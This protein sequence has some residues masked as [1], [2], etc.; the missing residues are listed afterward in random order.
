MLGTKSSTE[1]CPK[2]LGMRFLCWT[3]FTYR[4]ATLLVLLL[5]H[6]ARIPSNAP[7]WNVHL[8][9]APT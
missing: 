3:K 8:E 2:N 5:P 4:K 6:S 7:L 1:R 9:L